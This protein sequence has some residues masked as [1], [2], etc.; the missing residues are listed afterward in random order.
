M[1]TP[2]QLVLGTHNQKKRRELERLLSGLP[3]ALSTLDDFQNALSVPETGETFA[4]NAKLKATVQAQHL[5][6][7]VLGED[8]GLSVEALNGQPGVYSSR[9]AGEDG[10]DDANN[11]KL[12]ESLQKVPLNKRTAWYTCHMTLSDPDGKVWIDV[13]N[14]CRGRIVLQPRG[15]AGFGYDPYFEIPEYRMTF[16]ELGETVKSVLSHRARA[17]REF[18]CQLTKLR[19]TFGLA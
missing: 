3:I 17:M 10:N 12:V 8:S 7:W 13:E 1:T 19:D 5:Q 2:F 11:A 6:R 18:L 14:T 16:A 4:D 9:F 15:Q